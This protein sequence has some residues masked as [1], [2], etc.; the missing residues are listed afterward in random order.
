MPEIAMYK[1]QR[2]VT[3]IELVVT[4]VILGIS[5]VAVSFAISGGILQSTN[6]LFEVRAVALGQSYLDEILSKKFDERSR[7][8]G[9]PPC[10]N[11]LVMPTLSGRKCANPLIVEEAASGRSAFDDV[12]DYNGL[13]EGFG[14]L[15]GDPLRD[16][17]GNPRTN[18]DN[19][20][21]RVSV[22]LIDTSSATSE[23]F[24]GTAAPKPDDAYDAKLI[25]VTVSDGNAN[26]L[27]FSA[28]KSNF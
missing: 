14:S 11:P 4:I 18:Y 12:D 15:T 10:K 21:V 28:Y 20:R 27:D 8:S 1:P 3:L 17:I 19:F 16:A 6:T 2:G 25:T 7:N 26:G 24:S 5:L 23:L 22:R 9:V 13:D